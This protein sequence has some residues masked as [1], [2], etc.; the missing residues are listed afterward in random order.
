[1]GKIANPVTLKTFLPADEKVGDMTVSQY[2]ARLAAEATTIINAEDYGRAIYD[3]AL[4]RALITIGE[5]VVNIAYDAPVDMPP[6][7]DRGCRAPAV[8]TG[9]KTG[10]YD[11]GFQA[12]TTRCHRDRHGGQRLSARR[13]PFGHLHRHP[14][15]RFARMGGLQRSDLIV[16][17]GRPGMGKTSLATNI[18]YNIAAAYRRR[19]AARRQH[20]GQERR[21]RRLLLARNVVRAARHAYHFRADGS[22]LRRRSAAATSPKPISKSW[23]PAP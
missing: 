5:D 23:S 8:R 11:G 13:R 20:Q 14:I 18:A 3:L 17:A 1:M 6:R 16:L 4:R 9:R 12:S 22:L 21:R 15:A 10:R 2:L 19:S 7:P